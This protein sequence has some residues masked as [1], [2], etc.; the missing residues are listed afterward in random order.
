[1]FLD[2]FFL[3]LHGYNPGCQMGGGDYFFLKGLGDKIHVNTLR[4][5]TAK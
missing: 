1:M 5:W 2:F 3:S 4:T